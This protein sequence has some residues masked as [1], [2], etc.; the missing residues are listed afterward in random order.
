M[1]KQYVF[2][3]RPR[4]I[5]GLSA[6]KIVSILT[7]GYDPAMGRFTQEDQERD[8]LNWYSYCG[9]D[10]VN[11]VDPLGLY[12]VQLSSKTMVNIWQVDRKI[13]TTKKYNGYS[14]IMTQ[15]FTDTYCKYYTKRG[16]WEFWRPEWNYSSTLTSSSWKSTSYTFNG[17]TYNSV[18][19]V[20]A[21]IDDYK[22]DAAFGYKWTGTHV[23]TQF[24]NKVIEIAGKLKIKPDDLM[25]AMAFESSINPTTVNRSSNA[26]G[27]IQFMPSTAKGLGTTTDKLAKMSAVDQ[28]EY[29][30]L[31]LKPYAGKMKTLSDI[32]MAILWPAA[33]G[34]SDTYV[35]WNKTGNYKTQYNANS[36]LDKNKD[37]IIT[38]GEAAQKV[39]DR[40]NTFKKK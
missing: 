24:K 37:G 9:G 17:K 23:T 28:M 30:Y 26:T 5:I 10:P 33:V 19:S 32:Y 2:A 16:W 13:S 22:A 27:L 12:W 21:A 1:V 34:K 20:T 18:S 35:L 29:V 14:F 6:K 25:A 4:L 31:Y 39:I 38:K 15:N 36:G 11:R 8:G 7:Q 3:E 40:R